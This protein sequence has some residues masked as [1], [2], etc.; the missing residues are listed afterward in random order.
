MS[1]DEDVEKVSQEEERTTIAAE[2]EAS[3]DW[4]YEEGK[5]LVAADYQKK[6]VRV[7]SPNP[8][9]GPN[10]NQGPNPNPNPNHGPSTNPNQTART[11]STS[12]GSSGCVEMWLPPLAL[13]AAVRLS[14]SAEAKR[15]SIAS[16][17]DPVLICRSSC[18]R[19]RVRV[20]G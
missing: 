10:R 12:S 13:I 18:I 7:R 4:L 1:S 14:K 11:A 9:Q 15:L 6:K 8:N 20:R 16:L 17:S 3:E 2:F 5:D 19:V